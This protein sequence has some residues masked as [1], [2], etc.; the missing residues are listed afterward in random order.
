MKRIIIIGHQNLSIAYL[1][2]ILAISP[3]IVVLSEQEDIP[4]LDILLSPPPMPED[5]PEIILRDEFDRHDTFSHNSKGKIRSHSH[6]LNN[7]L[8]Q[9]NNR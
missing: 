7:T 3:G 2:A 9:L 1:N 6:M 4:E 8:R 5:Y